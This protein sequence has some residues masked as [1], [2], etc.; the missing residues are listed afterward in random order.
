MILTDIEKYRSATD[1]I[2]QKA[3]SPN[4][5][6]ENVVV[7][8]DVFASASAFDVFHQICQGIIGAAD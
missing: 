8:Y 6:V 4:Q 1:G 3:D 2:H 7:E 5:L